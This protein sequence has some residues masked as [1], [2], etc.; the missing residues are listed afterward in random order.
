MTVSQFLP[1]DHGKPFIWKVAL[2][3]VDTAGGLAAVANPFGRAAFI[4]KALL[5]VTTAATGV[6]TADVGVA[7]NGTT[8]DN[9]LIDGADVGT[10]AILAEN[11]AAVEWGASE[12]VTASV[13]TGASA[14]IV[15][16]VYIHGFLV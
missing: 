2:A 10:A 7:A 16:H 13:A 1:Q 4:T 14:G 9:S 5:N 15:G 11:S 12:Y 3:E 8:S 6:C